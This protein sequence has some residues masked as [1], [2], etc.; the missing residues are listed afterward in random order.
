MPLLRK[1]VEMMNK[2]IDESAGADL[3]WKMIQEHEDEM[4]AAIDRLAS[5]SF[6]EGMPPMW[7]AKAVFT[8]GM[9]LAIKY[10]LV[11]PEEQI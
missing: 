10:L 6:T 1:K 4:L 2:V 7:F 3:V 8:A 9:S 5:K 11:Q